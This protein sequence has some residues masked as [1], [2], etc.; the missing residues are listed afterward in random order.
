MRQ[1]RMEAQPFEDQEHPCTS[2]RWDQDPAQ[3]AAISAK[4]RNA[5]LNGPSLGDG[6]HLACLSVPATLEWRLIGV[7]LPPC[8]SGQSWCAPR[9]ITSLF[10]VP[11]NLNGI[12]SA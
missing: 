8:F 2:N 5:T 1:P 7:V 9:L 10:R 6:N 12:L 3:A 11:E 4:R